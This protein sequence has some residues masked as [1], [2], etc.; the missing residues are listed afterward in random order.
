MPIPF[1]PVSVDL[2]SGTCVV[3]D[4]GDVV[5]A[6][7]ESCNLPGISRPILRDGAA[8]V[9]GAVLNSIPGDV[10]RARGADLVVGVNLDS[11]LAP[12]SGAS[13]PGI[14]AAQV[15][16]PG[17]LKVLRR[18]LE[19]QHAEFLARQTA[20]VDLMI[21]PD[22]SAYGFFHYGEFAEMAEIGE[23]AAEKAV[24]ALKSL[25]AAPVT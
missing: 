22:I 7:L 6:L 3:R 10:A 21:S 18:V 25:L 4:Q 1:Y 12:R 24:P 13:R 19:V 17:L 15:P 11:R 20:A 16:F 23:A 9:D 2:I 5:D 14:P 8:L